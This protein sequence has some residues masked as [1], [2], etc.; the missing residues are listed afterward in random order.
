LP[1]RATEIMV[2]LKRPPQAVFGEVEPARS[3]YYRFRISPIVKISIGARA[4]VPGEAM[5]G[6]EVE[7]V[8]VHQSPDEMAPYERLLESAMQGDETLF[9]REDSVEAQ[10]KIV[11]PV[12]AN[13]TPLFEYAPGTWSPPEANQ[14][15]ERDGGWYNPEPSVD[16]G[17]S[18][19]QPA[20]EEA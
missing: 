20:Q 5:H 6:E 12:L 15:I 4:K 17:A 10:W 3:N 2:E 1:V 7:L 14:L 19:P 9:V 13:V 8:A 18:G 11:D 16:S